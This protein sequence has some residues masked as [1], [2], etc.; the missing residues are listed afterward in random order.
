MQCKIN[1]ADDDIP[2]F[3]C[4]ACHPEL[5]ATREQRAALDKADAERA[6]AQ[7]KREQSERE[8][9]KAR[10]KLT[11]ITKHGEPDAD[12]VSAKIAASMR[13]KIHRLEQEQKQ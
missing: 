13:K 2:E 3:L 1:H 11:A 4:R 12:T 8:L 10:V 5:N 9:R 6:A 7:R